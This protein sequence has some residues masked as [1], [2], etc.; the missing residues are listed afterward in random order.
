METNL[1]KQILDLLKDEY[2]TCAEI[3]FKLNK[4]QMHIGK[5]VKS[6][7]N[8]GKLRPWYNYPDNPKY[9]NCL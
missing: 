9:I 4:H 7:V 8:S 1:Q 5:S 6:L 3:A 2:M